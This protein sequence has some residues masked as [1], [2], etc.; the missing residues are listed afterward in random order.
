MEVK[1]QHDI[2][3]A[4]PISWRNRALLHL[5]PSAIAYMMGKTHVHLLKRDT[6][7]VYLKLKLS[8]WA[9]LNNAVLRTDS[10][11]TI[12]LEIVDKPVMTNIAPN[13]AFLC[14]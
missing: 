8:L 12:S 7:I 10:G 9:Y 1:E 14:V 11:S 5:K 2:S 13:C 3:T 4:I 6:A